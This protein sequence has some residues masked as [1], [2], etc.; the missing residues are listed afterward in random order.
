VDGLRRQ[1]R[2][3]PLGRQAHAPP[4]EDRPQPLDGAEDALL[5]R[6]LADAQPLTY[7]SEGALFEEPQHDRVTT[8]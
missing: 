7:F 4:L 8:G 1:E 3:Q 6:L 2:H 5:G